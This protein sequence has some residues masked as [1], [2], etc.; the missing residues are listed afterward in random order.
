MAAQLTDTDLAD[1]LAL[2]RTFPLLSIRDD[3]YLD[4]AISR[5]DALI[6]RDELSPGEQAYL[7]ALSDL[8]ELYEEE[9]IKMPPVSGVD[10]LR[11]LM[12]ENGLLQ[13]DLVPL[14]GSKSTV[15]EVLSGKRPL[16]LAH[17]TKLSER[18]G[19][20]ADVFIDRSPALGGETRHD[21]ALIE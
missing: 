5:V 9:H 10:M 18:F 8:V 4:E 16:A 19:L 3:A 14:F 21:A 7:E 6:D 2:C 12:E 17:I 11:H 13:Q 1:Y 15:S 20:P